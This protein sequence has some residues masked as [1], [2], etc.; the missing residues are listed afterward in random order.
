[1]F[2]HSEWTRANSLPPPGSQ[3]WASGRR[4]VSHAHR[5]HTQP[6][7]SPSPAPPPP[8]SPPRPHPWIFCWAALLSSTSF[9]LLSSRSRAVRSSCSYTLVCCSFTCLSMS[10]C[11][12]RYWG[13]PAVG[14]G[15]GSHLSGE[16]WG[17][18]LCLGPPPT[19]RKTAH[20]GVFMCNRAA[21][22]SWA[23]CELHEAIG[24]GLCLLRGQLFLSCA[25][26]H[27]GRGA[28]GGPTWPLTSISCTCSSLV[29]YICCRDSSSS[30]F[31]SNSVFPSSAA[32]CK[33]G[34]EGRRARGT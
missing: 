30:L 3:A 13:R 8:H 26:G 18:W 4:S 14:M 24:P 25:K 22:D 32:K 34:W 33:S 17:K 9:W 28:P 6:W 2:N 5:A 16:G 1:M 29:A 12:V 21:W 11:L 23:G 20:F 31:L 10:S 27:P 15:V 19:C 7:A